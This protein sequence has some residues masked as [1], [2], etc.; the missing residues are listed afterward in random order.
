MSRVVYYHRKFKVLRLGESSFLVVR[1]YSNVYEQHSH[2]SSLR[3]AIFLI[4]LLEGGIRPTSDYLQ[5]SARRLLKE[6]EF[7][8]LKS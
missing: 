5:E 7:N 8:N 3:G 2:L 4:R 6:K 1:K